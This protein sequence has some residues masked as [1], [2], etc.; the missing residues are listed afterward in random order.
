[1]YLWPSRN[2]VT[3]HGS[4]QYETSKKHESEVQAHLNH[5]KGNSLAHLMFLHDK[6]LFWN[7][8]KDVL[9]PFNFYGDKMI[10]LGD[11]LGNQDKIFQSIEEVLDSAD[12]YGYTPVFYQVR[13]EMV[14]FLHEHGFDFFKLGEEAYVDLDAFSFSGKR[15]KSFDTV[16][17][18][19]ERDSFSF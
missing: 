6:F 18:K 4:F 14:P 13:N 8:E 2:L 9:F 11:P 10:I 15:G 3:E 7:R 1:M 19:F 16:K 12:R 5:Y 17:N